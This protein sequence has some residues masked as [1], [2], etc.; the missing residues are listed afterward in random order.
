MAHLK[1]SDTFS[2]II[3]PQMSN[4][5][6]NVKGAYGHKH[7]TSHFLHTTSH[8][9]HNNHLPPKINN[10]TSISS[11]AVRNII[12][13][14]KASEKCRKSK[15]LLLS[16]Y[17]HELIETQTISRYA[18]LKAAGINT[19]IFTA[20]LKRHASSTGKFMKGL[21]LNDIVKKI[22]WKSSSL[23]RRFYNFLVIN[24]T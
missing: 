1:I 18:K 8:K 19:K 3:Y 16:Y 5:K 6:L 15:N 20:H 9:K 10:F 14:I 22:G 24:N 17:K 7:S 4:I 23:F 21:S 2:I 12:E 13:Y 11:C